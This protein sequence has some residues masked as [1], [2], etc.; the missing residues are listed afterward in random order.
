MIPWMSKETSETLDALGA[1]AYGFDMERD[2]KESPVI[3][4]LPDYLFNPGEHDNDDGSSAH[5]L[6]LGNT[7]N[8]PPKD[9]DN[10]FRT[11]LLRLASNTKSIT[12][13][14]AAE[15][16]LSAPYTPEDPE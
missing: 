5:V 4:E 10:R 3:V 16:L 1:V 9:I 11:A 13:F 6:I 15:S 14:K 2:A 12:I 7:K 8:L